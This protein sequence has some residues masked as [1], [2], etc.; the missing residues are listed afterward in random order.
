MDEKKAKNHV[1]V[2]GILHIS[3]GGLAI[4]GAMIAFIAMNF[5]GNFV[6]EEEELARNILASVSVIIPALIGFFGI[7]DLL[8]GAALFSYKQWARV[9]VIVISAINC[10]NIP[11]GTA[12]GIY[13]IWAM[14]QPEVQNLFD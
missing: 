10:L 3:F 12:K 7:V 13:S 6:P 2:V 14:M 8:A 5:A 11:I 4:L 1:T 9:L